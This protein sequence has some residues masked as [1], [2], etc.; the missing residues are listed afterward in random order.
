[1][2]LLRARVPRY[3]H[4][5][6]QILWFDLED[7][8]VIVGCY[9]LW[10][11]VDQWWMLFGVVLGPWAFKSYKAERPRGIVQHT[12]V[13]LGVQRLHRYPPPH[14]ECFAE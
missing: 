11:V 14:I 2:L 3:L 5:P 4:L 8:A 10:L 6:L 1:M 7:I 12:L 13:R 9:A